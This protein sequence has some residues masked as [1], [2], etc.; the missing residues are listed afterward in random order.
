MD[1]TRPDV[2]ADTVADIYIYISVA[3]LAQAILAQDH[4]TSFLHRLT[5]LVSSPQFGLVKVPYETLDH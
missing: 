1:Q 4:T 5:K 2:P 3:I